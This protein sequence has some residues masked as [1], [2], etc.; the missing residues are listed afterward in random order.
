M[1]PL[2]ALT[3]KHQTEL[4]HVRSSDVGSLY[5]PCLGVGSDQSM[6]FT[7]CTRYSRMSCTTAFEKS[8]KRSKRVKSI[9]K[10]SEAPHSVH[11]RP[12]QSTSPP[13]TGRATKSIPL[14]SDAHPSSP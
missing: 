8:Q 12:D 11:L 1:V 10:E 13:P 6:S 5:L 14:S 3:T 9:R 2:A 7:T 4:I